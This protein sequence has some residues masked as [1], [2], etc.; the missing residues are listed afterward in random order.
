MMFIIRD[1]KAFSYGALKTK[2]MNQ[3]RKKSLFQYSVM[4]LSKIREIKVH[5]MSKNGKS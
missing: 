5:R 2:P 4:E 1:A 3:Y